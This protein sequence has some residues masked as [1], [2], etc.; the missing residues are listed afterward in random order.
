MNPETVWLALKIYARC[1]EAVY[2]MIH[3]TN[4][5]VGESDFTIKVPI[6]TLKHNLYLMKEYVFRFANISLINSKKGDGFRDRKV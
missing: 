1:S 2:K 5:A 4:H 6:S 3:T